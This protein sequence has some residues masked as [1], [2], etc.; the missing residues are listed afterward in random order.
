MWT[1]KPTKFGALHIIMIV[2]AVLVFAVCTYLGYR[3]Q[4]EKYDKKKRL[5]LTITGFS[6]IGLEVI[7]II[8]S[9]AVGVADLSLIP[10]QIC[11]TPMYIL[12]LMYF[13][14][15]EKIQKTFI[16]YLSFVSLTATIAYFV[17]PSAMLKPD[18]IFLSLYSA[19][20]HII[21]VG[22]NAFTFV[23]FQAGKKE[24]LKYYPFSFIIFIVFSLVAITCNYIAHAVNVDT[25][26]NFFYLH[27]SSPATFP[28]IDTLIKPYVPFPV[29]YIIFL[30]SFFIMCFVPYGI[31]LLIE[32]IRKK[33]VSKKKSNNKTIEE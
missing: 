22:I 19:I 3:Y 4:D 1:N 17:N 30:I 33:I 28:L 5:A 9:F 6:L 31:F 7:K 18:Y 26:V 16:S 2:L 21:L 12:I 11:S 20:F 24:N 32:I 25:V 13:V 15:N 23:S 10:F 27:P 14:K 8:F 29:Y